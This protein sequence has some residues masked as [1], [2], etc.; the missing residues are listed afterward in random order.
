MIDTGVSTFSLSKTGSGAAAKPIT[1]TLTGTRSFH[2]GRSHEA[3]AAAN[4]IANT[5]AR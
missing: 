5:G 1:I 3:S 2:E 4:A